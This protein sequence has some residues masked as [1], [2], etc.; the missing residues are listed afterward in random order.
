MSFADIYFGGGTGL[1][2]GEYTDT[3]KPLILRTLDQGST[4]EEIGSD[5]NDLPNKGVFYGTML[6]NE[7]YGWATGFDLS[8]SPIELMVLKYS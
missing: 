4:W 5:I 3:D 6:R 8:G 7:T 2:V 1:I